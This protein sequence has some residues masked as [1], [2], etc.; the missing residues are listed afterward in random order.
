MDHG[1][2]AVLL[3]LALAC[4]GVFAAADDATPAQLEP[5]KTVEVGRNGE[6][7]VNGRP[8]IPIRVGAQPMER[9]AQLRDL[10]VNTFFRN[11]HGVTPSTEYCDAAWAAGA[12]CVPIFTPDGSVKGHPA[13]LGYCHADEPDMGI[14]KDG[15]RM[16]PPGLVARAAEMRAVDPDRPL[17]LTFTAKFMTEFG[18]MSRERRQS[19]YGQAV[20]AGEIINFDIY[21]IYGSNS[22]HKLTW[23]ADGTGELVALS[24]KN[25][26]VCAVIETSKGSKWITYERQKDVLP[27][28]TRAEVWMAIIRGAR[29]IAYFMHAWRPEFTTF[30]CTPEMQAELKRLNGQ[31]ARLTPAIC[32]EPARVRIQMTM[33]EGLEG[34]FMATRYDGHLYIFAQNI[35]MPPK[36]AAAITDYPAAEATILV[37]GLRAGTMI[38]VLDEDRALGADEGGF[39][40]SFA[41]LAEHIYRIEL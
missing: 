27:M 24:G 30:N 40:D 9:F 26:V 19:Y 29:A 31:I 5:I 25:R 12:Y 11:W 32:A 6:L 1:L 18:K 4:L 33:Q 14:D 37:D 2:L 21:P 20:R 15:P 16:E 35:T 38:E 36:S 41:G 28:H 17:W 3:C 10:G 34:H 23:V 7:R 13:L 39:V 8:F 22:D